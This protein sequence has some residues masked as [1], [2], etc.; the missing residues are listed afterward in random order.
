[1]AAIRNWLRGLGGGLCGRRCDDRANSFQT[2]AVPEAGVPMTGR[3]GLWN[4]RR[5]GGRRSE[6]PPPIR[7]HPRPSVVP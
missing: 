4:E 1:M 3:N 5:A 2:K 6:R 7:A